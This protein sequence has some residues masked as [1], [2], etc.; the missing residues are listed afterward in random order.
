MLSKMVLFICIVGV[1]N[2]QIKLI[3]E[4]KQIDFISI[5]PHFM[6]FSDNPEEL[7]Y[8]KNLECKTLKISNRIK[9]DERGVGIEETLEV[10]K[11]FMVQSKE[12]DD[13]IGISI[14]FDV[15]LVVWKISQYIENIMKMII[16]CVKNEKVQSSN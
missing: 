7:Q 13:D 5:Y 6:L 14:N 4:N 3:I 15:R 2:E 1:S 8:M 9:I 11:K 16:R 12:N 10:I